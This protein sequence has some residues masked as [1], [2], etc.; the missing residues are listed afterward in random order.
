MSA[1]YE[2][3]SPRIVR[4]TVHAFLADGT[5]GRK[6]SDLPLRLVVNPLAGLT[7]STTAAGRG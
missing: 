6:C 2:N 1:E 3:A 5:T 7:A 4:S